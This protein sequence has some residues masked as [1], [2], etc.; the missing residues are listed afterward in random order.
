MLTTCYPGAVT[1]GNHPAPEGDPLTRIE[2]KLD[3]V[4]AVTEQIKPHLHLLTKLPG[5]LHNPAMR[6]RRNGG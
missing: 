6:W 3:R 4:L 2:E 5:W 1:G